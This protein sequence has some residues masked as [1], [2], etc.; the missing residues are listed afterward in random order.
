MKKR[1][2]VIDQGDFLSSHVCSILQQSMA[3][4]EMEMVQCHSYWEAFGRLFTSRWDLVLISSS[5]TGKGGVETAKHI[6]AFL[7][8]P[9]IVFSHDGMQQNEEL[10]NLSL[11]EDDT[12]IYQ[13]VEFSRMIN[14]WVSE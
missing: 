1:V 3:S 8:C 5:L 4:T 12:R 11:Q 13:P 14:N 9:V 7:S 6:R 10:A 2:L